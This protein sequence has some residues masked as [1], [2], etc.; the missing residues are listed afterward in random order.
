M[1]INYYATLPN[2]FSTQYRDPITFGSLYN[3]S[4]ST[5]TGLSCSLVELTTQLQ[6]YR[7]RSMIVN[8]ILKV[9]RK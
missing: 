6:S 9:L 7:E 3:S 1:N 5:L 8:G 2:P 4:H